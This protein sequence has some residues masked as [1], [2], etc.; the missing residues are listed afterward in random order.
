MTS[1]FLFINSK[2]SRQRVLL[3]ILFKGEGAQRDIGENL[4]MLQWLI[5]NWWN[6]GIPKIKPSDLYVTFPISF[7]LSRVYRVFTD[8]ICGVKSIDMR[9]NCIGGNPSL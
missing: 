7:S 5:S 2:M 6:R 4:I 9:D 1:N 8:V 3:T